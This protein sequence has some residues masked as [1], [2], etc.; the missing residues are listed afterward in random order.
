MLYLMPHRPDAVLSGINRGYNIASDVQYSATVGAALEAA[1]QGVPGIA[2]SEDQGPCHEV[3]DAFLHDVL[4]MLLE[5]EY[6]PEQI[7]NVNFPGCFLSECRGIQTERTVSRN[8]FYRDHYK[9]VGQLPDHGIRLMV[10]GVI[11]KEA[12]EGTD[13][14][15]ILSNYISIGTVRNIG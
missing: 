8:M 5:K 10:E 14:R 4:E 2:L 9:A 15:A 13:F 12:E 6:V 1:F 7:Y 3:T 11:C